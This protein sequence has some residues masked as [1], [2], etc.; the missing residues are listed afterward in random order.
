MLVRSWCFHFLYPLGSYTQS[1]HIT[2]SCKDVIMHF[3]YPLGSTSKQDWIHGTMG[4][5]ETFLYPLGSELLFDFIVYKL[6]FS[7]S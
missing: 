1:I 6:M 2:Y 5:D 4:R 7:L 3:L